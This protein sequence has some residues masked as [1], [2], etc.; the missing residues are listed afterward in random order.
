MSTAPEGFWA[1]RME[2]FR[3]GVG[4]IKRRLER[5]PDV[6]GL[7]AGVV[8]GLLAP[9]VN[10]GHPASQLQGVFLA[11]MGVNLTILA[12]L[13][14]LERKRPAI[15]VYVRLHILAIVG[16]G[17]LAAGC[18]AIGTLSTWIY[19]YLFA[20]GVGSFIDGFVCLIFAVVSVRDPNASG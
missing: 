9:A 1:R 4:K 11:F 10:T 2:S 17:A 13:G 18:G 19:R 16:A 3:I 15:R 5:L 8:A 20:I 7:A 14:L 12:G 6:L